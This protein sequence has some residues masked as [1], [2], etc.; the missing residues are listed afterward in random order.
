[1]S[2]VLSLSEFFAHAPMFRWHEGIVGARY[3]IKNPR[4]PDT[5]GLWIVEQ[6]Q[7]LEIA[8][9]ANRPK[10]YK[11]FEPETREEARSD[12]DFKMVDVQIG[13]AVYNYYLHFDGARDGMSK[14]EIMPSDFYSV[15]RS[16]GA[17]VQYY[18]PKDILKRDYVLDIERNEYRSKPFPM[19]FVLQD[20]FVSVSSGV[21]HVPAFCE[22]RLDRGEFSFS[23]PGV[24]AGFNERLICGQPLQFYVREFGD[25]LSKD[26]SWYALSTTTVGLAISNRGPK[27]PCESL[28]NMFETYA[29]AFEKHNILNDEQKAE[30]SAH[31]KDIG[32]RHAYFENHPVFK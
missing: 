24:F 1:M 9:H 2:A 18:I 26:L 28:K 7:R 3:H 22:A 6:P 19:R 4:D 29:N 5:A 30:F 13:D 20:C 17:L 12:Y 27:N 14:T 31:I 11:D 25:V 21:E 15:M 32:E 10:S 23:R 16:N 8:T